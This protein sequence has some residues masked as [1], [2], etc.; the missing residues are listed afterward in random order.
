[1]PLFPCTPIIKAE[2]CILQHCSDDW[3][4]AQPLLWFCVLAAFYMCSSKLAHQKAPHWMDAAAPLYIMYVLDNYILR[5]RDKLYKRNMD[6]YKYIY[7]FK[8]KYL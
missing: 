2:K 4:D 8:K 7:L 3:I 5:Q 1:M 6:I